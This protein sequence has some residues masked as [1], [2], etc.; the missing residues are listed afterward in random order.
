MKDLKK[1]ADVVGLDTTA[2]NECLDGAKH[3][4]EVL[5]AFQGAAGYGLTATPTVFINGRMIT[6]EA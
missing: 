3:R 6:G 2:F 5:G 1:H 4:P